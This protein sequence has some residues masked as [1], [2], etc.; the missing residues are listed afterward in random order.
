ML[1]KGKEELG[2][3]GG[4][5]QSYSLLEQLKVVEED[6]LKGNLYGVSEVKEFCESVDK[7]L[8]KSAEKLDKRLA[9]SAEK[10]DAVYRIN[11]YIRRTFNTR[12][13]HL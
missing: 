3:P 4:M 12:R 13:T 9:E 7:R 5:K 10:Q 8:A 2:P 1:P 11:W 6:M